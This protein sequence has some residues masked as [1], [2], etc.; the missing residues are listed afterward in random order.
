[1]SIVHYREVLHTL[2][3]MFPVKFEKFEEDQRV[4]MFKK[5]NP[6]QE[7]HEARNPVPREFKELK[8]MKDFDDICKSHKACALALLPAIT[9]IDYEAVNHNQK[10]TLLEEMDE[11]AGKTSSP[12]HYAWVNA[13]CHVSLSQISRL[14]AN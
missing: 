4:K 2:L 5:Q 10:L 7:T 9:S 11:K 6:G 13:T 1:M 8:G 14:V 3:K 12:V